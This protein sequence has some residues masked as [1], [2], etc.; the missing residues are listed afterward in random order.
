MLPF[1]LL[2]TLYSFCFIPK[3][4]LT[5]LCKN[6]LVNTAFIQLLERK[7]V[8]TEEENKKYTIKLGKVSAYEFKRSVLCIYFNR[9]EQR[10]IMMINS[11]NSTT[12]SDS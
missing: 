8:E 3:N 1:I 12:Y 10:H 9:L 11:E 2:H 7:E 5:F 6:V 4:F